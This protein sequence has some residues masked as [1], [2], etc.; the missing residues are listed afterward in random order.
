[1]AKENIKQFHSTSQEESQEQS[2]D[3]I[4]KKV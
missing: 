4:G 3:I 1:M 2:S